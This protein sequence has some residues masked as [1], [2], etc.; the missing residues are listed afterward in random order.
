[1][2]VKKIVALALTIAVCGLIST[3]YG[4]QPRVVSQEQPIKAPEI[5]S[6]TAEELKAKVTKNQPVTIIDVR[7]S[8]GYADSQRKIKGA[9]HVKLRRLRYRLSFEPLKKCL[10]RQRSGH[11]LCLSQR[12]SK[13]QGCAGFA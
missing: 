5:E 3:K 12:R 9:I 6:T 8:E 1:M 10:A 4:A 7:A 2:S 13:Y 11:L